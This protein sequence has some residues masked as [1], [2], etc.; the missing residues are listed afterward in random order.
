[1]ERIVKKLN[2]QTSVNS[3][4]TDT[5]V[6]VKFENTHKLLPPD[7]IN[8][9]VNAGERFNT[10]RQRSKFYRILGTINPTIS[11]PLFNLSDEQ[12][13]DLYTWKGFN[14]Y[15]T[16]TSLYRFNSPSFPS[17]ID[18]YLKEKDGWFGYFD[19]DVA[20]AGFCIY[21]DMEPKRQRFSF[22]P[23]NDPYHGNATTIDNW[24][25]TITY[26]ASIDSG[27]TMVLG[28][29]MMIESVPA[30]VGGRSMTAF[31]LSCEHNLNIGD[32]V[33]ISGTTNYDGDH[34]VVR[35]GLDN[36]DYKGYYFVVDLDP[37]SGF[38]GANSR[39]K[40]LIGD[41]ESK[42]YFRKFRK[43]KTKSSN[44][45]NQ[46]DYEIYKLGFSENYFNDAITQFM[47]NQDIDVTDLVDNLKRPLSE[48]YFTIIKKDS[49]N[50][51][52]NIS[53]GIETPFLPKLITSDFNTFLQDI[54]VINRIHN[55]TNGAP[56]ISHTPLESNVTFTN[57]N[58][59]FYGDLVE[60]NDNL[61]KETVLADVYYRFNT[62]NRETTGQTVSYQVLEDGDVYT[63]DL[64][65]RQEG[66]YYKAHHL[67]RIR[68]F[69]TYVEQGD[70]NTIDIPNYATLF[71][72]GRYLWRDLID[73]GA[74]QPNAE[75][76]D[77]PFINGVHYMY[78][79][80][81]FTI[82]RQDPF[83]YWGLYYANFPADPLGQMITD[84]YDV[85]ISDNVC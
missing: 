52:T 76:L 84:K 75:S 72:D 20:K 24:E 15:D 9:V 2:S 69:S 37:S 43:I 7:V 5:L 11:N 67:I 60:Y 81:C 36:G 23:D 27:H 49:N 79:N 40:K 80:Y 65:P 4:N 32:I 78:D 34:I 3:V 33:R 56:F 46:Y 22:L 25:I 54:P 70:N 45:I 63:I 38:V 58:N 39:M 12:M 66:Y 82:K 73:I 50:L 44:I 51:F 16:N 30:V 48:L 14:F 74:I 8:E 77:Y 83:N 26:P 18:N 85:N 61:L 13:S 10:E 21:Y 71:P 19:P 55:S 42:Y 31:G 6:N 64:G 68:D 17:N 35:T 47:F 41:V 62:I 57:L 29:L 53:S 1:M 59:D 28:G